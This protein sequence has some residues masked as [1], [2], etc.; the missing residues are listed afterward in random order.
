MVSTARFLIRL[1]GLM[2]EAI[3]VEQSARDLD[4]LVADLHKCTYEQD[5]GTDSNPQTPVYPST[6]SSGT[7]SQKPKD[8]APYQSHLVSRPLLFQLVIRADFNSN[9]RAL[10]PTSLLGCLIQIT[11]TQHLLPVDKMDCPLVME[12]CFPGSM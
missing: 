8:K 1:I 10:I 9:L 3:D 4:A 5:F 7:I 6:E 12:P 11:L 2:P